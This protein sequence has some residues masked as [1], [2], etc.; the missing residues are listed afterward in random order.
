VILSLIEDKKAGELRNCIKY[1]LFPGGKRIRPLLLLFFVEA[2]GG[3]AEEFLREAITL[4]LMHIAS[5]IH[6][7]LPLIDNDDLRRGKPTCHKIFNSG[8]A[9]LA[10]DVMPFLGIKN[11]KN[12]N[13]ISILTNAWIRLCKGQ[14]EDILLK[15]DEEKEKISRI[16]ENK[17]T[18]LFYAALQIASSDTRHLKA[19]LD[20]FAHLLG[21][22]FQL[23]NDYDELENGQFLNKDKTV[24]SRNYFFT[25]RIDNKRDANTILLSHHNRLINAPLINEILP[26]NFDSK[27]LNTSHQAKAVIQYILERLQKEK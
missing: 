8:I 1:A 20:H 15:G 4:E 26:I 11:I 3:V 22:Y 17:T 18:S 10:G 14:A 16:R 9:L 19:E 7:D 6:D 23:R 2:L 12:I 21:E 27:N 24:R 25:Q 5:L 13:N